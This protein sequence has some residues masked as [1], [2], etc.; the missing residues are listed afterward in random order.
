MIGVTCIVSAIS[1]GSALGV[2]ANKDANLGN[3]A[4]DMAMFANRA[5]AVLTPQLIDELKTTVR[6]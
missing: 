2:L 3:L 6:A 5:G 4:Y 1:P